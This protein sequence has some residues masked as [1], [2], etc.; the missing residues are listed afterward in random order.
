[1]EQACEQAILQYAPY[2]RQ[3]NALSSGDYKDYVDTVIVIHRNHYAQLVEAGA[4]E[5]T[6]LPAEL[7][8]WLDDN[9]PY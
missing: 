5:W 3:I 8:Q 1:M 6:D 4:T 2:Y 7:T 9:K